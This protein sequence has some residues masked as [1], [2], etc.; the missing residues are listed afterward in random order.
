MN[1][2]IRATAFAADRH[3]NQRRKDA[4]ASPYINHPIALAD[5]LANE[6]DVADEAVLVAA[7]LHD[8]I[9]DTETSMDELVAQF[10]REA[11]AIVA[12]VT[13]DK[14]LPKAERKR[15]QVEHASAI[16]GKAQLVKLADK[17]CNLRDIAACPPADWSAERKRE[18]F[19]WAKAVVDGLRGVHPVLE[20]A[21]D[22][23][24]EAKPLAG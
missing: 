19:D 7:I 15:L 4:E 17:I 23:A 12:E 9:E 8:T 22:R 13:D 6:G 10:G 16:S 21:F 24:Y 18:Y 2:L 1:M 20:A 5:V 3:R 14:T 11:A